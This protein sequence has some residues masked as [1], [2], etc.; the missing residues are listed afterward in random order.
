MKLGWVRNRVGML[1]RS[2][3][4]KLLWSIFGQVRDNRFSGYRPVRYPH[5]MSQLW[6]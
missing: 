4:G 3:G 2:P 6:R 5:M 1:A